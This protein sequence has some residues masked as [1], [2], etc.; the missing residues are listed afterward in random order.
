MRFSRRAFCQLFG[1]VAG[2]KMANALKRPATFSESHPAL[3]DNFIR[4]DRNENAYGPASRVIDAIQRSVTQANRYARSERDFLADAIAR[5]H[6]VDREQVLL[7]A[8]STDLLRMAAQAFL[9][10]TQPLIVADPTFGALGHYASFTGVPVIKVPLTRELAH[11]LDGMRSRISRTTGLAYLCSPNN[12]TGTLTPRKQIEKFVASIPKTTAVV[13]DEAYHEYAGVSE[14]YTS[15][16]DR[17]SSN[18]RLVVLRT[19]SK[20]YGLAGLRLGY[21]VGAPKMLDRM[22]V[23]SAE[24]SINSIVA[25]AGLA[26][27]DSQDE[28]HD[29]VQRNDDDRQEFFNQSTGRMLKPIDSHANFAFMNVLRPAEIVIEHFR[30][31]GILLGPKFPSM[32]NHVRISFGT[33]EEMTEFWRVWDLLPATDV[34]M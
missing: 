23:F 14:A 10:P 32:P 9:G 1:M 31:H 30:Q 34:S 3:G 29:R 16:I 28:I 25:R 15:F 20:A 7:G 24:D 27:L 8:G 5:F 12:P 17:G 22:K 26:A 6:R 19:F 2:L 11:D 21:A 33:P 18:D 13:V 4:L